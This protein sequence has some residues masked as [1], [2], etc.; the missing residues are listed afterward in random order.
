MAKERKSLK[1]LRR[2][3]AA[4]KAGTYVDEG[5]VLERTWDGLPL[6]KFKVEF[7][8]Q[9]ENNNA[10]SEESNEGENIADGSGEDE[11]VAPESTTSEEITGLSTRCTRA[12]IKS[13]QK[14]FETYLQ[15]YHKSVEKFRKKY[16]TMLSDE[17][18][19]KKNWAKRIQQ[20]R[21]KTAEGGFN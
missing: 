15:E 4:K 11:N 13:R 9:I 1:S 5:L 7:G 6:N 18:I 2:K 16:Q 12:V 14:Y 8:N 19:F 3:T 10:E 17:A 20:L 21:E